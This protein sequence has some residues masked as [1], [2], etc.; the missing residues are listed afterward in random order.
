MLKMYTDYVTKHEMA[1]DTY[2]ELRKDQR[3]VDFDNACQVCS[4][5]LLLFYVIE[6]SAKTPLSLPSI[7]I[8]PAQRMPRYEMLM[9][10]LLKQTP[11]THP[12][13]KNLT[14]ASAV[15]GNRLDI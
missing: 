13:F 2:T 7:L 15:Y 10:G 12:D 14:I 5:S 3:F 9:K 4:R 11:E 6:L 1:L 8:M